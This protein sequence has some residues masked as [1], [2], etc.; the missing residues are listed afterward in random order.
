MWAGDTLEFSR[1]FAE[2]PFTK[3]FIGIQAT[4]KADPACSVSAIR[5][6][7]LTKYTDQGSR[8]GSSCNGA[9]LRFIVVKNYVLPPL[10]AH[11]CSADHVCERVS[12]VGPIEIAPL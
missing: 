4:I 3:L 7:N 1:T 5:I 2:K 9:G 12:T 11:G 6:S 10:L 8:R